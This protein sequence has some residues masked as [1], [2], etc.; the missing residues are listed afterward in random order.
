MTK[1]TKKEKFSTLPKC[2]KLMNNNKFPILNPLL[3]N[4]DKKSNSKQ[5]NN[6]NNNNQK[7]LRMLNG[8]RILKLLELC[9]DKRRGRNWL[10]KS[11]RL[12]RI[13]G[14]Q[15]IWFLVLLVEGNLMNRQLID[16]SLVVRKDR[17]QLVLRMLIKRHLIVWRKKLNITEE[18]FEK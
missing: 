10:I 18:N 4:M 5:N 14:R 9:W 7:A 13:W 12:Y 6:L 16:I 1:L 8:R 11:N 17:K 2:V 15:M 3:L